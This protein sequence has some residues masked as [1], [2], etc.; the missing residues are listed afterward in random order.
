ME[1]LQQSNIPLD[2]YQIEE[3]IQRLDRERTGMV[4]YRWAF[5]IQYTVSGWGELV[6]IFEDRYECVKKTPYISNNLRTEQKL[7]ISCLH[8]FTLQTKHE[9]TFMVRVLK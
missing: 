7:V 9:Q 2:R 1:P 3:L 5:L 6:T 8:L 4:D